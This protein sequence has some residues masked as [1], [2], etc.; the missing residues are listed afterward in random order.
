MRQNDT[1]SLCVLVF[2]L[3]Y[4]A[5]A[6]NIVLRGDDNSQDNLR[7]KEPPM[8]AKSVVLEL[9]SQENNPRNSEGDFI[10]LNTGEILYVYTHY[11]GDSGDDH[12][13]ARLHEP[14]LAQSRP[15][16]VR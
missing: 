7:V 9:P 12:A 5:L 3:G 16:L 4:L 11:Y 6:A 15:D 2:F 13:S 1:A 10:R 8:I 14:R